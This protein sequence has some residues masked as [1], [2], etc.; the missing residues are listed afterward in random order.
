MSFKGCAHLRAP[1]WAMTCRL[2][3][4]CV[5]ILLYAPDLPAR[6]MEKKKQPTTKPESCMSEENL[7]H[8]VSL[9][10]WPDVLKMYEKPFKLHVLDQIFLFCWYIRCCYKLDT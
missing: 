6:S 7:E 8:E 1:S 10:Q 5:L 2:G 3:E 4:V 9:I